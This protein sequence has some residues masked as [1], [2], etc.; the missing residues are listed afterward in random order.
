[1][2]TVTVKPGRVTVPALCVAC[3]APAWQPTN[4]ADA[5]VAR[6]DA[7][8]SARY[9]NKVFT[10]KMSFALCRDCAA[11]RV[12]S[13]KGESYPGDWL[14]GSLG[15]VGMAF[16]V[17]FF[18]RV[19]V[20][21]QGSSEWSGL[22]FAFFS[23]FF[24]G[25]VSAVSFDWLLRRRDKQA[26]PPNE[27]DR[28][29]VQDDRHRLALIGQAVR[30][31][32]QVGPGGAGGEVVGV[33]LTFNDETFAR[34]FTAANPG[35]RSAVVALPVSEA[36][37]RSGGSVQAR[38]FVLK[39]EAR[40]MIANVVIERPREVVWAFF[41]EPANW[42][43]WWGGAVEAAE[44]REGGEVQWALGGSSPI[45]VFTPCESVR[46][47]GA[48]MDTTFVFESEGTGRTAV[49]IEEGSPKG[50]ASFKDGGAAPRAVEVRLGEAQG[51]G[52]G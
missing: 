1:M 50:G 42:E 29:R 4:A 38:S 8:G 3:G 52:R 44:W 12:R 5:K 2:S 51:L 20:F 36:G 22:T 26:D 31:S 18:V 10:E 23:V 34:A 46:L 39:G 48:W 7:S 13:T 15:L 33:G 9:G 41:T 37:P 21:E 49:R 47:E 6:L 28:R 40:M 19:V 35:A 32:P 43:R 45:T 17:A 16:L 24:I 27:E 11:A 30:I 25:V 14:P